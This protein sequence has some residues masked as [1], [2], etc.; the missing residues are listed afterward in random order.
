MAKSN[1]H[2]RIAITSTAALA[3]MATALIVPQLSASQQPLPEIVVPFHEVAPNTQIDIE[4]AN[5]ADQQEVVW[6]DVL[7]TELQLPV[8]IYSRDDADVLPEV[9]LDPL[10]GR[11]C[12]HF[13]N[14]LTRASVTN[15]KL[16][17]MCEEV[18]A[19]AYKAEY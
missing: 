15:D 11:N 18:D 12:I 8:E 5:I 16:E 4:C 1:W 14:T 17:L 19:V 13:E 10:K 9:E 7:D 3:T 2:L 6:V